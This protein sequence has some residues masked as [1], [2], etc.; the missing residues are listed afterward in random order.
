MFVGFR[1]A[2]QRT[3]YNEGDKK[4]DHVL[5]GSIQCLPK[6]VD[7]CFPFFACDDFWAKDGLW[8]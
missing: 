6:T 8:K 4:G 1:K 3:A 5:W 2:C 7:A